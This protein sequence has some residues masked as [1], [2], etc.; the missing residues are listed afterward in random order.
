V[1][2]DVPAQAGDGRIAQGKEDANVYY[3]SLQL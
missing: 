3:D 1:Y 2:D